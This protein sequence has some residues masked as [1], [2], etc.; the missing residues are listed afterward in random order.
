MAEYRA[1][2]AESIKSPEFSLACRC[3]IYSGNY[4]NLCRFKLSKIETNQN[5]FYSVGSFGGLCR[6]AD[7]FHFVFQGCRVCRNTSDDPP[8]SVSLRCPLTW[9]FDLFRS[10]RCSLKNSFFIFNPGVLSRFFLWRLQNE[11]FRQML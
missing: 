11:V 10:L 9:R 2:S 4:Y 8:R 3:I 5:G 6:H 1:T 7:L